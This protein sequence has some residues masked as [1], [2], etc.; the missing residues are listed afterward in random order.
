[1]IRLLIAAPS[2]VVRAGLEAL[3]GSDPE[4]E[5]A[6][7]FPDLSAVDALRPHVVLAA[8]PV[9]QLAAPADGA[10]PAVVL[11]SN[12]AQPAWTREA[13]RLGLRAILPRDASA[14]DVLAAVEAAARG[15]AVVDPH[16][17][18]MLLPGGAAAPAR[19]SQVLTP[20]ELEVLHM[21]AEGAANKT[22]AWKLGISEHTVKFHVASILGKLHAG[23]R[24]E[25]V[26]IG[27]RKGLILV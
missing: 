12:E 17:L 18:E 25:A 10:G 9:E 13:L 19:V 2:A 22:I 21:M 4:I 24:A 7:S 5:L 27:M 26:A 8:L 16:E 6:G 3:A 15:M 1:M 11:L 20:R 14:N 23:T